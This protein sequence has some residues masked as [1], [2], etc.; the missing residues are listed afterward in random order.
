MDVF[1]FGVTVPTGRVV[2]AA[3]GAS[4]STKLNDADKG[5]AV[6][7][8]ASGTYGL[9]ADGDEIE[10]ILIGIEPNTVNNGF[11]FGSVQTC[12][13]GDRVVAINKGAGALTIGGYVVAAAQ[14]A[15]NT[16]NAG[17]LEPAPYVKAGVANNPTGPVFQ[18]PGTFRWRVVSLLTGAGA[19][20]S[21]VLIE[22]VG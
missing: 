14:A 3:L 10:G 20:D 4:N 6:K 8:I 21:E 12:Y 7:L 2:S 13:L 15:R 19:V 16:A 18:S 17:G 9:V 11:S 5:K 1:D 22:R